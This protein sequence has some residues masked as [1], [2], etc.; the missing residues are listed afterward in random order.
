ME[1]PFEKYSSSRRYFVK[2][3]LARTN[4]LGYM[5]MAHEASYEFVASMTKAMK[6]TIF[7]EMTPCSLLQKH[8]SLWG[9]MFSQQCSW[10]VRC[11]RI[12]HRIAG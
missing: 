5:M 11:S 8:R 2:K 9:F 3:I 12:W 7:G 4:L 10:S 6:I 1:K